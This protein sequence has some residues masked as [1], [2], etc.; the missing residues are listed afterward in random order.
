MIKSPEIST[1]EMQSS[2]HWE[3]LIRSRTKSERECTAQTRPGKWGGL[4][5]RMHT[6]TQQE[7]RAPRER[8]QAIW[9]PQGSGA[10]SEQSRCAAVS[11]FDLWQGAI[12]SPQLQRSRVREGRLHLGT[13]KSMEMVLLS[14]I[15]GGMRFPQGQKAVPRIGEPHPLCIFMYFY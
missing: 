1:C 15:S 13:W 4:R 2:L 12:C 8:L 11:G 14:Y 9:L 6:R 3:E 10:P 7:G 5:R